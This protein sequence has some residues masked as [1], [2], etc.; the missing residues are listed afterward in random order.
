MGKITPK[1]VTT[2]TVTGGREGHA[3]SDE[4]DA[5]IRKDGRNLDPPGEC[6]DVLP[7]RRKID[8]LFSSMREHWPARR[9]EFLPPGA[10]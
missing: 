10:G 7:K 8:I 9:P 2:V 1:Y 4:G 3:V 6:G 5:L